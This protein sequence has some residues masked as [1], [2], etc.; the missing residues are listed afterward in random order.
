MPEL[1]PPPEDDPPVSVEDASV[2][3]SDDIEVDEPSVLLSDEDSVDDGDPSVLWLLW[4]EMELPGG[5]WVVAQ[6]GI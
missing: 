2:L 4:L 6:T 5:C 3:L 1:L